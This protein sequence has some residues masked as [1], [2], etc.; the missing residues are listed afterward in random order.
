[1]LYTVHANNGVNHQ[2]NLIFVVNQG[3]AGNLYD[4]P[5]SI[6]LTCI[7]NNAPP[8]KELTH[9]FTNLAKLAAKPFSKGDSAPNLV[10]NT[11][12]S[13]L[14]KKVIAKDEKRAEKGEETFS[15][16]LLTAL[17]E[18]S[19]ESYLAC[20][21]GCFLLVN[22]IDTGIPEVKEVVRGKVK[23]YIKTVKS[24]DTPG[25]KLLLSKLE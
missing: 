19:V 7:I 21:R 17:E 22:L 12:S 2:F 16:H 18:E 24:Q 3:F 5:T 11:A 23:P 6:T 4:P 25:A 14:L 8:C 15:S 20:N 9:L 10:E 13:M 1:M